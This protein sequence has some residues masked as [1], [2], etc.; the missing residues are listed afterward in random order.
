[1]PLSCVIPQPADNTGEIAPRKTIRLTSQ[2]HEYRPSRL[3]VING[4]DGTSL[5][6]FLPYHRSATRPLGFVDSASPS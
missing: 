1:M 2:I 4:G 5:G 6:P 3:T